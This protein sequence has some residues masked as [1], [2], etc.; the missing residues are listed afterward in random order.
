MQIATWNVNS[1]IAR[2]PVVL[3]WLERVRPDVLCLQETKC[4]DER[5]PHADFSAIGY[6]TA[7]WG[8]PAYNGVAILS[9]T[10]MEDVRQG[11]GSEVDETNPLALQPRL[12]VATVAG[13]N[14]VN[15]YIP[16]G[17]SV[18]TEKYGYKLRWLESLQ[19]FFDENFGRDEDV[20]LCGDFNVAPDERDVHDPQAWQGRILCSD[21]ERAGVETLKEWGLIDAFRL[22]TSEA[23]HFS[24]WDY[25]RGDFHRDAGLRIDHIWVSE[26]LAERSTRT[27]IDKEPRGW[28]RPSDHTP[29]VAEFRDE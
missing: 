17:Q 27:W 25:R 28:E 12:L 20:L 21:A 8:A 3:R 23:G 16:N 13:I 15:V 24:W 2:L 7:H 6:H 11:F 22:H 10:A 4:T 1:V 9:R 5:F 19:N 14:I 26:P 18:G 29:V